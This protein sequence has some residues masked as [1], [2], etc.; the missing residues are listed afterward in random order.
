[1]LIKT[2]CTYSYIETKSWRVKLDESWVQQ[3]AYWTM[4]SDQKLQRICIV[5]SV[6]WNFSSVTISPTK[7]VSEKHPAS[8]VFNFLKSPYIKPLLWWSIILCHLV[9]E[10]SFPN[11]MSYDGCLYII[12]TNH[13]SWKVYEKRG[14]T[15]IKIDLFE[16]SLVTK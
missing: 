1:M 12:C 9:S 8:Y 15:K 16:C 2:I 4:N 14:K 10:M 13:S 7:R 11:T 5:C 3:R 6:C